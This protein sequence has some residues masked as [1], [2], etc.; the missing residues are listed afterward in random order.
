[1]LADAG[2]KVASIQEFFAGVQFISQSARNYPQNRLVQGVLGNVN[3]AKIEESFKHV[4]TLGD[5]GKMRFECERKIDAGVMALAND[6]EGN[7]FRAFL[8]RLA[9]TVVNAAAGGFFGTKG[10]KVS[11]QEMAY[12]E[13]L[14]QKLVVPLR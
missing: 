4:F 9:E 11:P 1:M 8:V 14:K 3:P 12:V 7:Q 10:E 13:Q 2:S 5:I 6:E